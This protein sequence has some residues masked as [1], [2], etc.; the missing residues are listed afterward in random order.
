[1]AHLPWTA[2]LPWGGTAVVGTWTSPLPPPM[3]P[4]G[5]VVVVS[6]EDAAQTLPQTSGQVNALGLE[7]K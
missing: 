1:M 3:P 7:A 5:T 2:D 6:R 4:G